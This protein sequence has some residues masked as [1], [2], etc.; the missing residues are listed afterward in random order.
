M[1]ALVVTPHSSGH[2]PAEILAQMLGPD[3]YA[4]TARAARLEWMFTE[5]DPHT[6]VLF[7]AP[8]AF[9]LHASISR[10]VVDLNRQRDEGGNNGVIKL[11]D[12]EENPLYPAGFVLSEAAREE[13]LKRY[14]DGF[15]AEIERMIQAHGIGLLVNGHSMQPTGP[16]IGPDAGKLRPALC[17]MTGG[18]SHSNLGPALAHD[19]HGLLHKHFETLLKGQA[20]EAIAINSPWAS[21]QLTHRYA[22]KGIPGFGLEFNRALYLIYKDGQ[23]YPNDPIIKALNQAFVGFLQDA[24]ALL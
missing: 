3:F 6:E 16:A 9:N 13:R 2:I 11:T 8:Q 20:T 22:Q 23:E 19:L 1:P 18:D 10:F 24:V 21:D 12:F 4:A 7:H 15:H 17:L 5:G 14:W